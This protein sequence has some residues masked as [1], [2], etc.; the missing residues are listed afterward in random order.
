MPTAE[1]PAVLTKVAGALRP[2]GCFLVSIPRGEGEG[3][4]TEES[5]SQYYRALHTKDELLG[6]LRD[7]GLDPEWTDQARDEESGWLCVLAR[8]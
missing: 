4:E 8:R 5:G 3:W 7:A 1:L 2:E 6:L